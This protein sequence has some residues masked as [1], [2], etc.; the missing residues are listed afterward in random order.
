MGNGMKIG[1]GT[2]VCTK[3]AWA[4]MTWTSWLSC[5]QTEPC[6]QIEPCLP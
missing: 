5:S 3:A 1:M 2:G 4:E 6:S